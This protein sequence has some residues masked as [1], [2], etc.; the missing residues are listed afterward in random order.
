V[1]T[2]VEASE[3]HLA[4]CRYRNCSPKTLFHYG[5]Y[6]RLF[7]EYLAEQALP[8]V[9]NALNLANVRAA[10]EWLGTRGHGG[11]R[12]GQFA[13]VAFVCT[14]K[15]WAKWLFNEDMLDHD[16][17]ARL[18]RP[19]SILIARRPLEPWE[20]QALRGAMSEAL[21]GVRDIAVFSLLL[22]TGMRIGEL[23][24]LTVDDVDLEA[25]VVHVH[26]KG[27]KQRTL[28]FG[29]G[30]PSGGKVAKRLRDY[31]RFRRTPQP[32]VK[33]FFLS[34]FAQPM[35]SSSYG[36]AFRKACLRA[37]ITAGTEV[38][39]VRHT[40]ATHYLVSHPGDVEGL[41][42]MLGHLDDHEYRTYAGEAGRRIAE[43]AGDDVGASEMLEKNEPRRPASA[44][45][46]AEKP[47]PLRALP[48]KA[49][50]AARQ[51]LPSADGLQALLALAR[52][53]PTLRQ[54]LLDALRDT[55]QQAS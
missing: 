11:K 9:L 21:T 25:F 32:K 26:G 47:R 52:T 41:R 14:L 23:C 51:P 8:A 12:D 43:M 44:S 33:A 28:R 31:L 18:K 6:E 20:V 55:N 54:A 46:R 1:N 17:L 39:R 36:N 37:G 3:A 7:L 45:T 4:D 16:P 53:D 30:T 13:R 22:G 49:P 10:A 38:H 2:L 19:K 42:Y 35:S 15:V 34:V 24:G 48:A 50:P 40:F 5:L 29:D 27:N